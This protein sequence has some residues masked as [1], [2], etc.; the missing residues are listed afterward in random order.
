MLRVIKK[1]IARHGLRQRRISID[2]ERLS[3]SDPQDAYYEA[4]RLLAQAQSAGDPAEI[5]HWAR[6]AA[7]VARIEARAEMD[8][9]VV[10]EIADAKLQA[11]TRS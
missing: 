1:W 5:L 6:V 3:A 4:H 8:F 10:L 11:R 9:K 2:A 7:E